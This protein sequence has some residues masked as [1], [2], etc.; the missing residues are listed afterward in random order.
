MNRQLADIFV[1]LVPRSYYIL[2]YK[3][4]TEEILDNGR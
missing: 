2:I 1:A 3:I 4:T